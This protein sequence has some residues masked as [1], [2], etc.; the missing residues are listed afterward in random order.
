MTK[1]RTHPDM[2]KHKFF[3]LLAAS[4]LIGVLAVFFYLAN[5]KDSA[6]PIEDRAHLETKYQEALTAKEYRSFAAYLQK[7]VLRQSSLNFFRLDKA[8]TSY[9]HYL[10]AKI[11]LEELGYAENLEG[12]RLEYYHL[13]RD[14]YGPIHADLKKAISLRPESYVLDAQYQDWV[15]WM[16]QGYYDEATAALEH[17]KELLSN[18]VHKTGDMSEL[19]KYADRFKARPEEKH[20]GI[21]HD[22]VTGMQGYIQAL[23][24]VQMEE[25]FQ[26]NPS[27]EQAEANLDEALKG[28]NSMLVRATLDQYIPWLLKESLPAGEAMRVGGDLLQKLLDTRH[29]Q[30]EDIFEK[31]PKDVTEGRK[32]RYLYEEVAKHSEVFIQKYKKAPGIDRFFYMAGEGHRG[33]GDWDKAAIYFRAVVDDYP[34]SDL[35]NDAVAGA[36]DCYQAANTSLEPRQEKMLQE[37][38]KRHPGHKSAAF[39]SWRLAGLYQGYGRLDEALA[40]YRRTVMDYPGTVFSKV[41]QD[42]IDEFESGHVSTFYNGEVEFKAK[43]EPI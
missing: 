29:Q 2:K 11:R 9:L 27:H 10:I 37:L 35:F 34:D 12:D 21:M 18:Y 6:D 19:K 24:A 32:L 42:A 16:E 17:F 22:L 3:A 4:A 43:H 14:Y 36:G 8:D 7:E 1:A 23:Y 26:K 30:A 25:V 38:L 31:D 13:R 40:L 15:V 33:A 28:K 5:S 41:S 39:L 20:L